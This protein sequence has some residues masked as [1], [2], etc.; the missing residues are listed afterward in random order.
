MSLLAVAP[1]LR[2]W[3]PLCLTAL[4][5]AA[6]LTLFW[7]AAA[8]AGAQDA[9][10]TEVPAKP[11]GL[12]VATEPGS[13]D[14]SVDWDD[15]N[16]VDDYLVR[17]RPHGPDQ[18]LNDG[19][20]PT[21]SETTIMVADYGR[22]VLRAQA[23]NDAGCSGAS[24]LQF[25]VEPAPEPTPT[26]TPTPT[27]AETPAPSPTPEPP[28][29]P[30]GLTVDT[31][32][33]S[34]D[35]GVDWGDV[36]GADGYLVRWRL[37]GPDQ[38]LND[39]VRPTSSETTITVADYG[40]WVVRVQACNDAGCGP[41]ISQAVDVAPAQP[42]ILAAVATT[43]A[44]DLAVTWDAVAG[45]DAY[46]V[47]WRLSDG[48]F[49]ADHQVGI[50]ADGAEDLNAAITVSEYDDWVV[51]VEACNG[52][53][54]GS[55]V[56]LPTSLA[57]SVAAGALSV[58]ATWDAVAGADTYEVR[59]RRLGEAFAAGDLVE[60]ATTSA[61]ITVYDHGTWEVRVRA[62][63][64]ETCGPEV[65]YEANVTPARPAS[66][67]VGAGSG[68]L[69]RTVSWD[70][71]VRAGT[72]E[73]RWGRPGKEFAAANL[74]ETAATSSAITMDDHGAW[75]VQVRACNDAGCSGAS[76][77]QFEVEPAQ[78]PLQV[79]ITASAAVVPVGASVILT[80]VITNPPADS[81]PSYQWE[82]D[83]GHWL[84]AG[85]DPTLS[86]LTSVAESLAFRV[87]VTY[88]TGVSGT[89]DP[90]TVTWAEAN[91]AP[92]VNEQAEERAG[93]IDT[94]IAPRG[95]LVSK[96]FGGI[97]SD[98]D[99]DTLTYT[100]SVPTDRTELV[101]RFY[102]E[103]RIQRVF[104]RMDG[105]DDWNAVTPA[106]P[107]PLVTTV[108]LTAT[109][110]EGLSASVS[111]DFRTDWDSRP[112]LLSATAS[113]E[114]I[115]L[116]FDQ[117]LQESPAPTPGQ[118][119]VNAVNADGGAGTVPVDD[120]SVSGATVTLD[121]ASAVEAGQ[122][123]TLDYAHDDD[124][125]LKRAASG[126]EP[127]SGFTG[128]AVAL[129]LPDPPGQPE[130]LAVNPAEEELH[131]TATWDEVD[132]ATYYQLRWRPSGGDGQESGQVRSTATDT[133]LEVSGNSAT[134]AVPDAGEWLVS[135]EACNDGGCGQAL[136]RVVSG[137]QST[138]GQVPL[139]IH[140]NWD[141]PNNPYAPI[142]TAEPG[143]QSG[144]IT[145]RWEPSSQTGRPAVSRWLVQCIGPGQTYNSGN[146]A[147]SARS[148]TCTNRTPAGEYIVQFNG[149]SQA[150][151]PTPIMRATLR[152]HAD[153]PTFISAE[154]Q[155][156]RLTV[157]FD[158]TLDA[159]GTTKPP[160]SVFTVTA[161][162]S[163][164]SARTINGSSAAVTLDGAV[165]TAILSSG[166]AHRETV[167]LAYAKPD[168][169][170]LQDTAPVPNEVEAFTGKPVTNNAPSTITADAGPDREVEAGATVTLDGSRS[171][172][173]ISGATLTYAW[174]QTSGTTV[175]LSSATAEM[176]SFTAPSV[177]ADLEFSL[178]V[179]DGNNDSAADTVAVA[180]R[181]PLNPAS[182]PCVHPAP[183]GATFVFNPALHITISG[184]S[185]NAITFRGKAAGVVDTV[186]LHFCW[187]D[188]T[189]AERATGVDPGTDETV[190]GLTSGTTYWVVVKEN[191]TDGTERWTRWHQ[192][193]TTGPATLLAARFTSSPESGDTYLIGETIQAQVTWSRAVTVSNG[194][195]NANVSL[196][197]DLGD[198]DTD[199]TNSQRKMA[200][201]SGSGTDTLTFEYKVQPDETDADGVWL[202]TLS[203]TDDTIVFLENGAT[204]TGGNPN[205]NSAVLTRA[206]LPTSG[207]ATRKVD[208]NGDDDTP[209]RMDEGEVTGTTLIV[210]FTE[211]LNPDAVP[212]PSAFRVHI[213]SN[214][215][216]TRLIDVT[217]VAVEGDTVTLTLASPVN[218]GE[219]EVLLQYNPPSD[220][221]EKLQ[222]AIGNLALFSGLQVT[223]TELA[224]GVLGV[225][226][227]NQPSGRYATPGSHV[228]VSVG[229]SES[230][231]VSGTPRIPL[232]PAF[233]PDGETRYA[234]YASGS[235]GT[236]LV[237][238]YT[239]VE[240]DDS[241]GVAVSVA[242]EALDA[243][244]ADGSASIR[245]TDDGTDVSTEHAEIDSG[246]LVSAV[247][248]TITEAWGWLPPKLGN[249][250]D[251][252]GDGDTYIAGE[253]FSV[254]VSFSN[255]ID[256]ANTGTNG[257]DAQIVVDVGGTRYTLNHNG[258]TDDSVTF[259]SHTVLATDSDADG[260]TVVRDA[261]KNLIRLTGSATIQRKGGGADANLTA[262][263]DLAIWAVRDVP[264]R[265][266][267]TNAAPTGTDF[268]SVTAI[269]VDLTFARTDFAITDGDGDPLKE[270][271]V[272]SLP[273]SA[274]GALKLDG[275]AIPSGDLPKTVTRTELEEGKLVFAPAAD[276]EGNASFT[277]KVVDSLGAAAASSNTATISVVS[278]SV[279]DVEIVSTPSKDANG[280]P[281][282]ETY[283]M[284][285]KVRVRLTFTEAVDVDT[286]GGRPRLKIKMDPS[287]GEK[288][289][290][291]EGGSGTDILTFAHTVVWPNIST[292]GIA[293]LSNTLELNGGVIRSTANQ[294]NAALVNE[295]LPH[296]PAHQVYTDICGR[297]PVVRNALVE[298]VGKPCGEVGSADLAGLRLLDLSEQGITSLKLGDLDGLYNLYSL[299][300]DGNR[301]TTL[302]KDI[303]R[304]LWT[305][306]T[307][308][309]DRNPLGTL[310][311]N[312]FGIRPSLEWLYLRQ[313]R[314]TSIHADAFDGLSNLEY[315][316]LAQNSLT[317]LPATVFDGNAK[318]RSVGLAY[319]K[320]SSLPEGVFDGLTTLRG[321]ALC[322]NELG[323]LPE[324][325][326]DDLTSLE[327]LY[328]Q[329]NDLASLDVGV[330]SSLTKLDEL[331]LH[332]NNFRTLPAS[333][334]SGLTKLEYLYLDNNE[335]GFG[336]LHSGLF[337]GL[338]SLRKLTLDYNNLSSL[339]D[340][341]FSGLDA[342]L[343]I[344]V[345]GIPVDREK[346]GV[347]DGV[348]VER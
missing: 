254:I 339:P 113:G 170:P 11:A 34:L 80:T 271:Q 233:G 260:I 123:V 304:D 308:N 2:R 317:A 246:K 104:I 20:R 274:H 169:N 229:F 29:Q 318:L 64:G 235:P 163:S 158:R 320:I 125:P 314:L 286:T 143:P 108:T 282:P 239:L 335:F 284:G 344:V 219:P 126:G 60:T 338:T 296:D 107:D 153:V 50:A 139:T 38:T 265:V 134:F 195:A 249:D 177:R 194:G 105:D 297:T 291:Y 86:Y 149:W 209:P 36:D 293:V 58:A 35:V 47:R 21:S 188:G 269:N 30:D 101:E 145:V 168:S 106:L 241:S 275:T 340:N 12:S 322:F 198:D 165:V 155:G 205:T 315:L 73:V 78:E 305:V 28:A 302:P 42:S 311:A 185:N 32:A 281:G 23:C 218:P 91:R 307:I 190:G 4:L 24:A 337:N 276:Y 69:N 112:V 245:T 257:A 301:L 248:P 255:E 92:V 321:L 319:N 191:L 285:E 244:G 52:G 258:Q 5:V 136:E 204:L 208:G 144:Q 88:D 135:L 267:G 213:G 225:A 151:F 330:F 19:V 103:D 196:R 313:T 57:I 93:F 231:T 333:I 37:H 85:T 72:Y 115:E 81:Q 161:T 137:Q 141:S 288:W 180:V 49:E 336:T 131:L 295:G 200:Y 116:T 182:A 65:S 272:L 95:I 186:D 256:V 22:W 224:P 46:S 287:Y 217:E 189:A 310:P 62:C 221:A 76:L 184:R 348:V 220:R 215:P 172:S 242:A 67:A 9:N 8:P 33:G 181:L 27:P 13:L 263:A 118:F 299:W 114:A 187:P 289:A 75:E 240:G 212:P 327:Y 41:G 3:I 111:G 264:A 234:S 61:A 77:L 128:H 1:P 164:G 251:L 94:Y 210:T 122:V 178:V 148:H 193:S 99:G 147:A 228:E 54:C 146:L 71:A 7:S 43:G 298:A 270:I 238:R 140:Q 227:T 100:V 44:L 127:A 121:L 243:D 117:A 70:S 328:L 142:G 66:L 40:R 154:V 25:D 74:V 278:L 203:A 160:G 300:L 18:E 294:V 83:V 138:T 250:A 230:V 150:G 331:S 87:T 199:L 342:P 326:F 325:V 222:D 345:G 166:V 119:T 82:L 273:M 55:S 236:T 63:S 15:V 247:T 347:E 343:T 334:F 232:T 216:F 53:T 16:G 226:F 303:F 292:Q 252:D 179:N 262:D 329:G 56:A 162:P 39:G 152:A 6:A 206:N 45:A 261:S 110:P 109:D 279:T 201:A 192:T 97:F 207:D 14:V 167:T 90:F 156:K 280:D 324:G 171:S 341:I 277:F 266:R 157:T 79:S 124:T 173:P 202:Q 253:T 59:W 259:G 98:P 211:A 332:I 214:V 96:Q 237:F 306:N 346:W 159:S 102:V 89:S 176:P 175:T 26:T 197:L 309:L 129:A 174:S 323:S 120:V 130:N 51:Q 290:V 183:A 10:D 133:V 283:L 31:A 132:G 48:N 312:A 17:W 316:D 223:N 84:S 68:A 268:T